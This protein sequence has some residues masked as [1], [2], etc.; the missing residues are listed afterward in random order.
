V[1][2]AVLEGMTERIM[3]YETDYILNYLEIVCV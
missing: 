1:N 3:I 2:E